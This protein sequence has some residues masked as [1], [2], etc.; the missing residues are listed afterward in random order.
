MLLKAP[1]G[2][3]RERGKLKKMN[4]ESSHA[5]VPLSEDIFNNGD[6][7][8]NNNNNF[9][10]FLLRPQT[11]VTNEL[12]QSTFEEEEEE[13][14]DQERREVISE[15]LQRATVANITMNTL[16]YMLVPLSMPAVFKAAGWKFG[17]VCFVSSTVWSYWT[18]RVIGQAYL[19]HPDLKTYPEMAA[20][21]VTRFIFGGGGGD[22]DD[23]GDADG[24]GDDDDDDDDGAVRWSL[25]ESAR[26]RGVR[27]GGK[28]TKKSKKT[29][30]R[31]AT[32]KAVHVVQ[33]LTFYLDAVCQLVYLAQYLAML[34]KAMK[35]RGFYGVGWCQS[36]SLLIVSILL[37]PV[38]QLPTFHDSAKFVY[39]AIGTLTLSVG[40]FT[41]EVLHRTPWKSCAIKPQFPAVSARSKFVSLANFAY[42]YGGHG[43]YPEEMSEM[44][45]PERWPEVMNWSYFISAPVYLFVGALGYR[46]YGAST[47]AD[48]NL[49]FPND[50]GNALSIAF[51]FGQCYYA[52]F[53]CNVALCSRFEVML[54]VDPTDYFSKKHPLFKVTAFTFRL[55]FRAFFLLTQTLVAAIFLASKGDVLLD[56][57]GLV[58]SFGMALMTFLLPSIMRLTLVEDDEFST[59]KRRNSI[60]NRKWLEPFV[61]LSLLLGFVVVLSGT[62]GS[63]ADLRS[64]INIDKRMIADACQPAVTT[65]VDERGCPTT[66]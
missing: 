55:F 47:E 32:R 48:I 64:D 12:F 59:T 66:S 62:Y 3:E 37:L 31:D 30:A 41:Y 14:E 38:V 52:V 21:A 4:N 26:R 23:N 9:E 54:G 7:E 51:Q 43:L 16:N 10:S 34:T 8:H 2:E 39:F 20:E 42:A 13:H 11:N 5:Y 49:N 36:F 1:R 33:F 60:N 61:Y 25:G 63:L 6:D 18:G 57:Q 50:F 22:D 35:V 19:K 24:G 40:V 56:L 29:R 53:F 44:Q 17:M 45:E 28:K 58:G 65:V 27:L 15:N 46:S